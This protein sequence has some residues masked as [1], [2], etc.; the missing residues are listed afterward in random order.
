M[1]YVLQ[2][3]LPSANC[4]KK[5]CLRETESFGEDMCVRSFKI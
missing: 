1:A 3:R 4:D 2:V 5:A